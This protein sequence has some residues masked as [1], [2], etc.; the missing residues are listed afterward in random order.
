MYLK[1][2]LDEEGNRVYTL[3]G[4]DPQG[5]QTQ[6]AHPARFSPEDKNSKYRIIIKKRFN[7]LPT[8]QPKP[9][10]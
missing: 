3:K 6:S 9:V 4:I 10:Y 8:M 2:Y 1:F 5:R 7:I